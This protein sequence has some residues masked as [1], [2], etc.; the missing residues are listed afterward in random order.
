M[1][2]RYLTVEQVAERYQSTP[3]AIHTQRYRG[4][5]PGA[6]GVKVG[7]RVLWRESDLDAWFDELLATAQRGAA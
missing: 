1:D 7:K 3:A 5:K 6:L 4:E 2:T